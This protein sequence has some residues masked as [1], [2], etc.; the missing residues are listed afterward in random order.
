MGILLVT[1]FVSGHLLSLLW[2]EVKSGMTPRG[3]YK[4]RYL[5][6]HHFGIST[7]SAMQFCSSPTMRQAKPT[8]HLKE[9]VLCG[10]GHTSFEQQAS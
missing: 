8:T 1:L 2:V 5:V 3:Q 6:F 7:R 9:V 10:D 4:T